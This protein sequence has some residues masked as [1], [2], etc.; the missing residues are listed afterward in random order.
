MDWELE[1]CG[2]KFQSENFAGLLLLYGNRVTVPVESMKVGG[3]EETTHSE[4]N[5]NESGRQRLHLFRVLCR[6]EISPRG[7][8]RSEWGPQ[9][10]FSSTI[11]LPL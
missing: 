4:G 6:V 1:I 9:F 5:E 7:A 11:V 2:S 8:F 3:R 10:S